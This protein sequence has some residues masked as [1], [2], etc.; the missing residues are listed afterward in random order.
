M[1]RDDKEDRRCCFIS[2]EIKAKG[3][4]GLTRLYEESMTEASTEQ[5]STLLRRLDT[6]TRLHDG[7]QILWKNLSLSASLENPGIYFKV[8]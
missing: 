8:Y 3:V 1:K 2:G 6:I 7:C 5:L 4:H